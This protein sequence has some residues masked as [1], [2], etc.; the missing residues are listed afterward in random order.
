[1]WNQILEVIDR[2]NRSLQATALSIG[3]GAKMLSGLVESIQNLR[4]QGVSEV[5]ENANKIA[6]VIGIEVGFSN[7]RKRKVPRMVS[8]K[9]EDE[10]HL[11]THESSFSKDC[12]SVY[13]SIL[14]QMKSRFE[15]LNEISSNFNF[16]SGSS[17]KLLTSEQLRTRAMNLANIYPHDLDKTEFASEIASFKYQ[18]NSLLSDLATASEKE[19]LQLIH[20]YC[21]QDAYPNCEIALRIFLTIPVTEASCERSFSKLKIIKNYLR[22]SI[23]QERLSGLAIISIEN[24]ITETLSYERI[25]TD[26]ASC[27]ARKVKF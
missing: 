6:T 2:V 27:K 13:D 16:L 24:G 3:D 9:A 17:L 25:I 22:S 15:K 10:G 5:I 7:K 23:G 19:L 8:E 20:R 12:C 21:L 14:S 11:L 18:A 4:D 26:F 1:M